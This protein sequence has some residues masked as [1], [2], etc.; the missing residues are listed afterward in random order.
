MLNVAA[1]LPQRF[2]VPIAAVVALET[3]LV[4]SWSAGFVGVRFAVEHA[5]I[6]AV[7]FW[8]SLV[9]GALLLPFALTVGPRMTWY[10]V[11]WQAML[12][13][14]AMGGYL[15]GFALAISYGVPTGLVALIADMLPLAVALLSWPLLGQSLSARQWLGSAFGFAGVLIA[16]GWSLRASSA[17]LWAFGLPFL[18]TISMAVATL[19]QKRSNRQ[20]MP[21]HQAI[22]VQCLSAAVIFSLFAWRQDALLPTFDRDFVGGVLWLVFVATFGAYSL[23]Y[24]ALRKFSPARVTAIL[25]LSPPVTMIWA[26]VVFG[27]PLSWAMALGLSVSLLGTLIVARSERRPEAHLDADAGAMLH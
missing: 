2:W 19:L 10:D 25:Y 9:S 21:M 4:L 12:G 20:A 8:R 24:L 5:P 16:S 27:E 13:T 18:G 23:Y 1:L 17:P 26:W 15:A 11:T 22:C 6:F 7:L 3:A 14:L